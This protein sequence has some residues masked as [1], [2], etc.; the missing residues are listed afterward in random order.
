MPR[1]EEGDGSFNYPK[2]RLLVSA[3][4]GG[5]AEKKREDQGQ[6]AVVQKPWLGG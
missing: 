4:G 1:A 2:Y 6:Y 5:G 3:G